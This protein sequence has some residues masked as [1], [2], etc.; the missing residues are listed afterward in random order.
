MNSATALAPTTEATRPERIEIGAEAR[1]D[2][3]LLHHLQRHGQR[4]RAQQDGEIVRLLHGEVA[5][6]L[7]RAAEDRLADHR[8]RDHVVVEDDGE[9]PAD[10][11]LRRLGEAA[12]AVGV[13]AEGDDRLA[14]LRVEAR[15]GVRQVLAGDQHALF[16]EIGDRRVVLRVQHLGARGR[17]TLQRLLRAHR[18]VD[19]AEGELGGL[20]EQRLQ[21]RGIL[22]ARHLHLDAVGA[23]ALD[24][25]LG[26][27]ELVDTLAD[28]LDGLRHR[29][30]GARLHAGRGGRRA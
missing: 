27:A 30:D 1:S 9:G 8:R 16:D 13:E 26:G 22:Q 10:I 20:A 24:R 19:E 21:A 12:R 17:T 5:A 23:L 4:A 29:L 18:I 15:L 3:A 28:D 2:R 25:R 7:A 11:G 6:D 14:G